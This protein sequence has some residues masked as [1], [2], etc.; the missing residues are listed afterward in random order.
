MGVLYVRDIS[1]LLDIHPKGVTQYIKSGRLTAHKVG[2]YRNSP[3]AVTTDD[4][5]LFLCRTPSLRTKFNRYV[6]RAR[7]LNRFDANLLDI[8]NFMRVNIDR[9]IY[10]SSGLATLLDVDQ[11]TVRNWV[12]KGYLKEDTGAGFYSRKSVLD[13]EK[14]H[15]NFNKSVSIRGR[16]L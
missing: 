11:H 2:E 16:F 7:E 9:F 15:P 12:K 5:G 4:F 3:Y 8:L 1:K 6:R 13:L 14:T 10:S